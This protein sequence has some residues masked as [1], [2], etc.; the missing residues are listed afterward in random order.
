VENP[1]VEAGVRLSGQQL[2]RVGGLGFAQVGEVHVVPPG[3]E[4]VGVPL[5]LTVAEKDQ[6][7]H[8]P[9]LSRPTQAK[10]NR[11]FT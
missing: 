9:R 4:I 10:T 5:G 11:E 6:V 7:G 3:E 2:T 8:A 1:Q